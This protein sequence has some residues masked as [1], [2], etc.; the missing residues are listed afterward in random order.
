MLAKFRQTGFPQNFSSNFLP[1]LSP[2]VPELQAK[3]HVLPHHFPRG[4]CRLLQNDDAVG[5]GLTTASA[6]T[7]ISPACGNWNPAIVLI[8]LD[9]S[10]TRRSEHGKK[11][12]SPQRERQFLQRDYSVSLARALA[13]AHGHVF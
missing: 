9:F 3:I 8:R 11:I 7:R 1:F 13:K 5:S 2:N 6:S 12:A 4:E 10:A